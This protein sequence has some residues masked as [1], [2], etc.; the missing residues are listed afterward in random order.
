M[1]V[2]ENYE[3]IYI[4]SWQCYCTL[5]C[6]HV[7][8]LMVTN[9]STFK[10]LGQRFGGG[11]SLRGSS[12]PITCVC[13]RAWR[14]NEAVSAVPQSTRSLL[15]RSHPKHGYVRACFDCVRRLAT[16]QT[17]SA[18]SRVLFKLII[19]IMAEALG[20]ASSLIAIFQVSGTIISLCYEYQQG[21]KEGPRDAAR[22]LQDVKSTQALVE[23]LLQMVQ[24]DKVSGKGYLPT[25]EKM[26]EADGPIPR[27]KTELKALKDRLAVPV[28]EW[29][30]IGRRLLWPLLAKDVDKAL[31]RLRGIRD[32]IEA[33]L[34]MDTSSLVMEIRDMMEASNISAKKRD[35]LD[36]LK[37][38]SQSFKHAE[39]VSR[40][41]PG[42]AMWL[43]QGS[44]Y[45][46]WKDGGATSLWIHGIPGCGKSILCS[47]VVEDIKQTIGTNSRQAIVHFY[48]DFTDEQ[49]STV[50]SL[51]RSLVSQILA[52]AET[53]PSAVDELA[54]F[55]NWKNSDGLSV[56]ELLSTFQR[57]HT[58]FDRI[59]FVVDALDE[60]SN[61]E[62]LLEVL[63]P[64][65]SWNLDGSHILL[66]SRAEATICAAFDTVDVQELP[67]HDTTTQRDIKTFVRSQLEHHKKLRKWPQSLKLEIETT[68]ITG[69]NGMYVHTVNGLLFIATTD[70]P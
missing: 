58:E 12:L 26:N 43:L 49:A 20:V 27:C 54:S 10:A 47:A 41:E 65:L 57:V 24:E 9:Q 14:S 67:I 33:G 70:T 16:V 15:E 63:I 3:A 60:C 35:I 21:V 2:D 4:A 30:R 31:K 6:L 23:R 38:P 51:L 59:Y 5:D 55:R 45:M 42:T 22:I 36:W 32:I 11:A 53:I 28:S 56:Q 66:T 8:S 48:F 17:P 37:A 62:E 69:S 46:A 61:H 39:L 40:R 25:L 68:L 64:I 7:H 18:P 52:Q 1:Q 13:M 29:R 50:H 34:S 19:T 44:P